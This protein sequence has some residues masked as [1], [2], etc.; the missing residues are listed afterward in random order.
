MP[1]Y[2]LLK[3][4]GPLERGSGWHTRCCSTPASCGGDVVR[5]RRQDIAG[6]AISIV[7]EKTGTELSIPI[8]P[9][10][11]AAMKAGPAK[12]MN[13]I[14]DEHGR[15]IGRAALTALIKRAAKSAGL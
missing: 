14:G 4:T 1:S 5:M 8:H 10:L 15:P 11:H 7:Q 6:G 3:R 12:G 9:N 2:E 13:L